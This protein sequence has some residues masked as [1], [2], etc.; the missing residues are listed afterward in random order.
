MSVVFQI[1]SD[2][3]SIFAPEVR[4]LSRLSSLQRRLAPKSE[5][6]Q[7]QSHS[8]FYFI[9][10]GWAAN[11]KY[12]SDGRRQI[13]SLYLPGDV[14]N[15][16]SIVSSQTDYEIVGITPCLVSSLSTDRVKGFAES[17]TAARDLLWRLMRRESAISLQWL[18]SIGRRS[19]RESLAHLLCEMHDRLQHVGF[20]DN[21]SFTMPLTQQELGDCLGVSFVHVNRTFQMFREEQLVEF[22]ARR[23]R[24]VGYDTLRRISEF[25]PEYLKL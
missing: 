2:E 16:S 24:L 22:K 1:K 21:F 5:V 20:A 11:C 15:L 7:K 6:V 25:D 12:L 23:M 14:C 19:T 10:E 13:L 8:S 4:T 18:Y 9:L 17:G 3:G